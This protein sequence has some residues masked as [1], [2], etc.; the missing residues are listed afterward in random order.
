MLTDLPRREVEKLWGKWYTNKGTCDAYDWFR[1]KRERKLWHRAVWNAFVPPKFSFTTWQ[2]LKGR[3]PTRDRLGYLGID[4]HCPLCQT[5]PESADHLFFKCDKTRK[6]WK[7]IK[8]WLGMRRIITTIPSAIKW[9]AKERSGVA[10]IRKAR[11][12]ALM[13]TVNLMWRAR[14]ALI[15][16]QTPFDPKHIVFE[17]KKVT[18]VVLYSLYPHEIVQQHLGE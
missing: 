18:Y 17:V 10:A 14:N 7:E 4:Q 9:M 6:V 1:P 5:H 12:L 2:A 11:K 15:F 3:L 16:D 13:A 8:T